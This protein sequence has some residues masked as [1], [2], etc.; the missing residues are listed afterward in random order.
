LVDVALSE[1][2]QQI[3]GTNVRLGDFKRIVLQD[4]NSF[5]VHDSLK[6][7]FKGRF[8]KI[9]PAV[10]EAHVSWDVLKGYPENV[11]VS[12]DSQAEYDFLPDAKS[13]VATFFLA[14]RGYFKL[15]YLESIDTAGG[16][17]VVRA[18]TAINPVVTA[19]YNRQG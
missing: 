18:K 8:T 15:S 14:D 19:A 17:Y 11:S 5:A 12:P 13:L 3:L 10:I 1:W 4:G 16:F 6:D 7:T 2:Q 9:S